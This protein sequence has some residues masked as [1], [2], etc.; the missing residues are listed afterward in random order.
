MKK[1]TKSMTV[2]I[3]TQNA[4]TVGRQAQLHSQQKAPAQKEP[5]K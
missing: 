1:E 2:T 4:V 5:K 3:S